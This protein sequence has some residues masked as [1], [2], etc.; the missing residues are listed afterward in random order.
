MRKHKGEIRAVDFTQGAFRKFD[1]VFKL[2]TSLSVHS[3]TSCLPPVSV[4]HPLDVTSKIHLHRVMWLPWFLTWKFTMLHHQRFIIILASI[5]MRT[6]T[7][8]HHYINDNTHSTTP[9]TQPITCKSTHV[10]YINTHVHTHIR[11]RW[12]PSQ[13]ITWWSPGLP[14][15]LLTFSR[16][17]HIA[18]K[19]FFKK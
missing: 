17:P 2:G 13:R 14:D 5:T 7:I 12:K 3:L 15:I 16:W 19:G 6:C 4:C 18:W 8:S 9:S 1:T 11:A 10:L